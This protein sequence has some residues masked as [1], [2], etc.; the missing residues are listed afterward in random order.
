MILELSPRYIKAG[1]EG[2]SHPIARYDFRPSETRRVGDYRQF[3]PGH[4]RTNEALD[5]RWG[6]GYELW[7]N[8]VKDLDLGL[9]SDK[10]ERAVREIYNKYLL[11]DAGNSRLILVVPSLIAHPEIGRAHV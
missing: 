2:E 5:E 8:D 11:Q 1:L 10:L 3:L 7:R 4:A 9:L 6:R